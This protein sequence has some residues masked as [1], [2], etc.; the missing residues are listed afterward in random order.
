MKARIL[1]TREHDSAHLKDAEGAGR[2][3][4][5]H[6][7]G[8]YMSEEIAYWAARWAGHWGNLVIDWREANARV[9]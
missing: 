3:C 8:K 5:A 7:D 6:L 4:R 9:G 1:P 2:Y